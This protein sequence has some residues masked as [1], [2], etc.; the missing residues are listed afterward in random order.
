MCKMGSKCHFQHVHHKFFYDCMYTW[1]YL[2]HLSPAQDAGNSQVHVITTITIV[3][4]FTN[5]TTNGMLIIY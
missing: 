5:V 1:Q 2:G 3:T 4:T